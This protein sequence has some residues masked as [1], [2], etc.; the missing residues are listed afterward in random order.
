MSSKSSQSEYRNSQLI[1]AVI[2][3]LLIF[4]LGIATATAEEIGE[5][6]S[7]SLHYSDGGRTRT[8]SPTKSVDEFQPLITAGERGKSSRSSAKAAST[9]GVSKTGSDH[10]WFFAADVILFGD[11]D[12]DG[13]FYGIDLLFDVDT[14]FSAVDVYAV[15]YLSFEG[16]PWNEYAATEDFTLFASS[17]DD[18]YNIVTELQSGYFTGSYDVL[19]EVFDAQTDEYLVG[20]GPEET[21]ALGFLPLEDFNRDAPQFD[22]PVVSSHGHG[23]GTTG[24]WM[25][26]L[27]LV[28]RS[29]RRSVIPLEK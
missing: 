12:N 22:V 23:G 4:I 13:Y 15:T 20:F 16:G 1:I 6:T 25:L 26:L 14:V 3:L 17:A 27:L 21:S 29:S 28:A 5:R 19:I 7:T 10:F 18:E 11:D 9:G 2:Y 8:E 24:L